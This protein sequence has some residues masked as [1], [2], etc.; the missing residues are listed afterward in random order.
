MPSHPSLPPSASRMHKA[1]ER[2]EGATRWKESKSLYHHM[3]ENL[4]AYQE[5]Q[6]R[7]VR[8]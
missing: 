5:H 8:D 6:H 4:T 2:G 7:T 1:L 3:E